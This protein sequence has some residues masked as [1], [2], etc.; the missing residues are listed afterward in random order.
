MGALTRQADSPAGQV[1]LRYWAAARAAAGVTEDVVE[2][3]E[4]C[5]LAE[6]KS[7]ALD[8]HASSAQ[9]GAVLATCSVLLGDRPVNTGDPATVMVAPGDT[10]EFLPPF[11]G[12]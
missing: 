3:S 1:R 7:R 6:L 9:F 11:A 5:T 4:P 2:L 10:V 12:G 8:L